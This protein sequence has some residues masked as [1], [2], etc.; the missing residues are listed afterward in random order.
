[1]ATRKSFEEQRKQLELEL[2]KMGEMVIHAVNSSVDALKNKNLDEAKKIIENDSAI[3]EKQ[4]YIE[5][6]CISLIATQQPVACD[7]RDLIAIMNINTELERMGDYAAGNANIVVMMGAQPLIKPLI[8]I[9]LMAEK[10]SDMIKRSLKA[11]MHRD[12]EAARALCHEDDDVDMLYNRV[13]HELISIMIKAP[14]K[15]AGA[16]YLIW[17]AHNLERIADRVTNIC[18]RTVYLV[19][20]EIEE[21]NVSKY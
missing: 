6:E 21:G 16:T 2:V 5:E 12:V 17:A 8:D 10:A 3:N 9:P 13:Y 11:F 14:E 7:L 18:E 1:M 4:R 15:T 20:G 19:T